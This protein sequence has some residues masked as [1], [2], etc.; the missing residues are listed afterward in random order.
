MYSAGKVKNTFFAHLYETGK[1][2]MFYFSEKMR[3]KQ[4][5]KDRTARYFSEK[6]SEFLRKLKLT[7]ALMP[8]P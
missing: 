7:W 1:R 3:Q 8:I 2:L 5:E 4:C 6:F